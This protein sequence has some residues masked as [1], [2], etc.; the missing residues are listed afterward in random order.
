MSATAFRVS[1]TITHIDIPTSPFLR[2]TRFA[3]FAK[4]PPIL[5]Y[6]SHITEDIMTS[7]LAWAVATLALG[8]DADLKGLPFGV[9]PAPED[10]VIANVAPPQCLFYVNWAGTASPDPASKNETEKM[11]V[12]PEVQELMRAIGKSLDTFWRK[13]G[14]ES[15]KSTSVAKA[16]GQPE[17]TVEG[18]PLAELQP[19]T[20]RQWWKAGEFFNV[21]FTHPTAIFVTDMQSV[22]LSA[23]ENKADAQNSSP[24]N[25]QTKPDVKPKEVGNESDDPIHGGLVANLGADA[26]RLQALFQLFIKSARLAKNDIGIERIKIN[27]KTWYRTKKTP[28]MDYVV[29]FGFH[30]KYF[31]A[32][33]GKGSLEDILARWNK[34]APA[35]FD[36]ALAQTPVPRRTGMIYV[37]L[38]AIRGK[39]LALAPGYEGTVT[40]NLELLGLDKA[41]SL[42]ST[43][44][45]EHYGMINRVLL[46][47]DGKPHGLL[48]L[49]SEKPLTAADL[50]P[51]PSNALLAFAARVDLDHCLTTVLS[52]YKKAAEIDNRPNLGI[53]AVQVGLAPF[54]ILKTQY[55]IDI[56]RL[57]SSLGDTWCVYNSPTEGEVAFLGWTAVVPVRDRKVLVDC[58]DKLSALT[59]KCRESKKNASDAKK[60][61]TNLSFDGPLDIRKCRFAGRDVYYLAGQPIAPAICV[62]DHEVVTTLNMPAM[63]AYLSRKKHRSLATL[64]GV[65]LALKNH[66]GPVGLY[67]CNSP[68]M[69]DFCYPI[70][71]AYMPFLAAMAQQSGIDLDPSFWP[72]A[73]S[74]RAHLRPDITTVE[75]TPSGLQVTSRYS[76]PGQSVGFPL[77]LNT[78]PS[79]AML[80]FYYGDSFRRASSSMPGTQPEPNAQGAPPPGFNPYGAPAAG[81]VPNPYSKAPESPAEFIARP[82]P[83]YESDEH[84]KSVPPAN[85]SKKATHIAGP[86]F[87][88]SC[89]LHEDV[90]EWNEKPRP[91]PPLSP[92]AS[93]QKPNSTPLPEKTITVVESA[94]LTKKFAPSSQIYFTGPKGLTITWDVTAPGS[95][96]S[97]ELVAPARYNFPQGATYH[98]RL[99]N[100]PDRPGVELFPSIEVAHSPQR[101]EEFLKHSAIPIEFTAEDFD[102]VMTC[103]TVTKVVYLPDPEFQTPKSGGVQTLVS[104]KLD[105]GCDPIVEADRRGNI[106][107]IVGFGTKKIGAEASNKAAN[108]RKL[109]STPASEPAGTGNPNQEAATTIYAHVRESGQLH[110]RRISIKY[111]NAT[112]WIQGSVADRDQFNKVVTAVLFTPGISICRV[113]TDD[114]IIDGA[115]S[116]NSAQHPTSQSK[117]ADE[118]A[119]K[120]APP[121]NDAKK[122]T[123]DGDVRLP[124]PWYLQD[125]VQYF[126][127]GPEFPLSKEAQAQKAASLEAAKNSNRAAPGERIPMSPYYAKN[128]EDAFWSKRSYRLPVRDPIKPGDKDADMDAPSEDETMRALQKARPAQDTP[129][130][131]VER[132][133]VRIVSELIQDSIDPPRQMPL[134]GPV[135]VHHVHFKCTVYFQETIHKLGQKPETTVD[136]DC[137]EV[138]YIDHDHLHRVESAESVA[139]RGD[140]AKK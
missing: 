133:R 117:P 76:L 80:P 47:M 56:E 130:C 48:D 50:E 135:Q 34:P 109:A 102:N 108:D 13:A 20:D 6:Q 116:G 125:D 39:L 127:P 45:L 121:A 46:A 12:E 49:V 90:L 119:D 63:K 24:S 11:L 81:D 106:L 79:M 64:P 97:E 25:S 72:S 84:G 4:L 27:G 88:E 104:T 103:Q 33:I 36:K 137:Q 60:D 19:Q 93:A 15:N 85:D 65:A 118:P 59:A 112:V 77:F 99:T 86:A 51:I 21:M 122:A 28:G 111:H 44:G 35:W 61:P 92:T 54:A 58:F 113:V 32:G 57:V 26:S 74:I 139:A 136:E 3:G 110:G 8:A 29:T 123:H 1:E 140:S 82:R 17:I 38:K 40:A 9:P 100:L 53:G 138:I 16:P 120:A 52:A 89:Q 7:L 37:N 115:V 55:G 134:V 95:Y 5:R 42:V 73:P 68:K 128:Q 22:L 41:D 132:N 105:P 114:L 129:K 18:Q 94:A 124:S 75:R 23:G 66:N 87:T 30:G 98:L 96:D 78:V 107:A 71:S 62:T 67:Y 126:P 70:V 91:Q 43:T 69:F 10:A 14:E 83:S 31:V 2:F 101:A 131:T